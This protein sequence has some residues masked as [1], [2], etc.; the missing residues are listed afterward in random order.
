MQ[1]KKP[2]IKTI[3]LAEDDE[4]DYLLF[5]EAISDHLAVLNLIWVKDGVE[6]MQILQ[7]NDGLIVDILFLDINMP[8]KNGFEC[9]TEIRKNADLKDL[10][11]VVCSTSNDSALVSWMYNCGAN[12]YLS[13]PPSF[14]QLKSV[15]EKAITMDW[16]IH[17]P[18]PATE[19]F[20]LK[21]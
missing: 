16:N 1:E 10:P 8:R 11:V 7:R 15:I 19:D 4:D 9:L 3:V 20:M 6:L 13:K 5:K 18:Y 2:N 17:K 21:L 12:L 14:Q